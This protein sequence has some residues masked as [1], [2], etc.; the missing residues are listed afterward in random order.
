[1]KRF[2]SL[3]AFGVVAF[4]VTLASAKGTI[5]KSGKGWVCDIEG[6]DTVAYEPYG[7]VPTQAEQRKCIQAGGKIK[8]TYRVM[9]ALNVK[10]KTSSSGLGMT[11][12]QKRRICGNYT[13]AAIYAQR[14]NL[15]ERCGYRG[16]AWKLNRR[17]H[18]SWCLKAKLPLLKREAAKRKSAL[19]A[20]KKK[21]FYCRRYASAARTQQLINLKSRCNFRG[22]LWST[23]TT[24][25]FNVCMKIGLSRAGQLSRQRATMLRKCHAKKR[26]IRR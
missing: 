23:N 6:G 13:R 19:N 8:K 1:M 21:A 16:P 11:L 12:G 9:K 14:I 24:V 15:R 10:T 17:H 3:A 26:A 2:L 20:C 22:S 4:S 7:R 25:H 5:R 18:F